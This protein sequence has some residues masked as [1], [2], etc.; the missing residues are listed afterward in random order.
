MG[1]CLGNLELF[2]DSRG[3]VHDLE[4]VGDGVVCGDLLVLDLGE[5]VDEGEG[6]IFVGDVNDVVG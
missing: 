4:G 3:T 5:V 6:G 2:D 1:G